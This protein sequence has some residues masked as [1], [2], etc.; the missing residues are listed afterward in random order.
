MVDRLLACFFLFCLW[1]NVSVDVWMGLDVDLSNTGF[2]FHKIVYQ[3]GVQYDPLFVHNSPYMRWSALLTAVFY[4]PYYILAVISLLNGDGLGRK[5][6]FTRIYSWFYSIGMFLNMS[7]VLGLEFREYYLNS[8]LTPKLGFYWIPC[9]AYWFI[10]F[11]LLF[12]MHKE[13]YDTDI[14]VE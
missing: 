11:L 5:N 7:I 6:S 9:G 13:Y 14:K 10:P 8:E 12:R 4:A 2:E 1:G 3:Q